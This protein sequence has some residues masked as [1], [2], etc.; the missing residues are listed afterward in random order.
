MN[1]ETNRQL[2]GKVFA[3]YRLMA[4][5]DQLIANGELSKTLKKTTRPTM[6]ITVQWGRG[7]IHFVSINTQLWRGP[8]W[9]KTVKS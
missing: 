3:G 8:Q 7:L 5:D 4:V 2:T 1:V 6:I 9:T